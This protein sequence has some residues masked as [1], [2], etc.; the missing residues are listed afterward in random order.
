M[1]LDDLRPAIEAR[2]AGELALRAVP[3]L[4]GRR[5]AGPAARLARAA[6]GYAAAGAEPQSGPT[7][8]TRCPVAERRQRRRASAR[9]VGQRQLGVE[10]EQRLEHEAAARHLRVGQRQPLGLELE[11]AEQQ[12][13]DVERAR[14]VALGRRTSAPARPRSPCTRRA[15]PR[16]RARCG[17]GPRRSGSRAGRGS[18]PPA[19]SRTA[20][21]TASTSTPCSRERRDGGPQMGRAG[22]RRWSRGPGSRPGAHASRLLARSSPRRASASARS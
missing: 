2:P 13:V 20:E 7:R 3:G 22:R 12:Q 4:S 5:A 18:R 1:T 14:A 17:S 19:R 11:V 8:S 10:L 9:A 21:E 15:A 16:A 6:A